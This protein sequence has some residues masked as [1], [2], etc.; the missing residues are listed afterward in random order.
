MR[1]EPEGP[2]TD[3]IQGTWGVKVDLEP[4]EIPDSPANLTFGPKQTGGGGAF[5][6]A[7][8]SH[9]LQQGTWRKGTAL[10][11]GAPQYEAEATSKSITSSATAT[12]S[13]DGT[14]IKGAI[15][16]QVGESAVNGT[17]AGMRLDDDPILGTFRVAID[18][19]EWPADPDFSANFT[20]TQDGTVFVDSDPPHEDGSGHWWPGLGGDAG[21]SPYLVESST[22]STMSSAG[23]T[24]TPDGKG[25]SGTVEILV[26]EQK[27]TGTCKGERIRPPV[28][29]M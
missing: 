15:E 19:N 6:V 27:L 3:P 12:L 13:D 28:R 8:P 2:I 21:A 25:I 9:Q 7:A 17:F 20:F 11:D 23:F 5:S 16:I 24:L 29:R 1:P 4:V 18:I 10:Y 22:E 26:G 14:G